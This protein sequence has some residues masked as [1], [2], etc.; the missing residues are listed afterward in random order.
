MVHCKWFSTSGRVNWLPV[1]VCLLAGLC[2]L[3]GRFSYGL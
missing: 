1:C 3:G 2:N